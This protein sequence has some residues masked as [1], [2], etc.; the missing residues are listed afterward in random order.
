VIAE[1]LYRRYRWL[2]LIVRFLYPVTAVGSLE[3]LQP[4]DSGRKGADIDRRRFFRCFRTRKIAPVQTT[5]TDKSQLITKPKPVPV[6]ARFLSSSVQGN[7]HTQH[8]YTV[9]SD[10]GVDSRNAGAET[11][12]SL[13]R[14]VESSLEV[15]NRSRNTEDRP[16]SYRF[17]RV[18]SSSC[19][20]VFDSND[21]T[22]LGRQLSEENKLDYLPVIVSNSSLGG[23]VTPPELASVHTMMAEGVE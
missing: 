13:E 4:H 11:G 15:H 16:D 7:C 9:G 12:W 22:A 2:G 18:G 1:Y 14:A 3:R 10:V 8:L 23:S 5:D 21:V 6:V 17:S 19:E 20:V